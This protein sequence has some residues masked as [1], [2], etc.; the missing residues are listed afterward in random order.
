MQFFAGFWKRFAAGLIDV[1]IN[2]LIG[3]IVGGTIGFLMGASG[4]EME[5]IEALANV[6]GYLASWIY[7]AAFEASEGQ[8]TPGK[9]ALG[10]KVTDLNEKRISFGRASGRFFA[11]YLS[12]ALLCTGFI[13]IAFTK[14]KQGLHDMIAGCLVVTR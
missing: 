6:A 11:K 1:F 10:I 13:M 14:R 7:F 4:H 8:A 3:I 9:K 12:A 2:L 5:A